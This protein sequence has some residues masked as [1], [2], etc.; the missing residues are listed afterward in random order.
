MAARPAGLVTDLDGTLAPIVPVPSQ[1][2]PFQGATA[3]LRSLASRLPVVAVITGRAAADARSILGEAG[4]S[5]LVIG[6][7]GLEWLEPGSSAPVVDE[8][9]QSLRSVLDAVVARIAP[10][11]GVMVEDK[12]LSATIHYRQ[13]SDPEGARLSLLARLGDLGDAGIE[14]REGRRSFE[15]RP[16]GRGDKGTALRAVVQRFGLRGLI[17]A[18]DDTSDLDMF[19][20]ARELRSEGVTSAIFGVS[21]GRE[22]PHEVA[23]AADVLLPDPETFVQLLGRLAGTSR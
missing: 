13:A 23:A 22:V 16:V 9:L 14:L 5:V 21:G 4:D 20:S 1:A 8:P 18:G 3:V 17:V 6:N 7:H 12:G 11:E 15:L 19:Q 10:M 2:R